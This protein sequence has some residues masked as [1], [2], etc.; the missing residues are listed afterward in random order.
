MDYKNVDWN[1]AAQSTLANYEKSKEKQ[2][3]ERKE[4]DLTKYFSIA[5]ADGVNSGDK[6]IRLLPS[7]SDPMSYFEIGKFQNLK[8]G[9]NWTKLYDPAQDGEES[10]LTDMYKLLINGSEVDKK[11]A[12]QYKSRDFYIIRLIERGKEHE[13]VKWWRIPKV[14]DGSGV[15]DKI[16][17][18]IKRLNEKN[19]GTG[20]IWR[21]DAEGRDI[22]ISLV[23]DS[24]KNF[25]KISSIM[26]DDEKTP[27]SNDAAVAES[28]LMDAT[29]WKDVYKKK[30]IEYLR[31]LAEGS[32]P[33]WDKD[34]KKFVAKVTEGDSSQTVAHPASNQAEYVA[35]ANVEP[36]ASVDMSENVEISTDDLP[37]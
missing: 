17:P 22:I 3:Y 23:R 5:L 35:P 19:P 34:E 24:V 26:T 7:K 37:F 36:E 20:S 8:I 15:I 2:T 4:V 31:I 14:S 18:I 11:I 29:T 25:T 16:S 30:P 6:T 27:L 1:Q 9:K 33:V 32:E 12:T 21:P 10:P 28:W 13:G